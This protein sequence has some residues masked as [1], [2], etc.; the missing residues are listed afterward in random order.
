MIDG[1]VAADDKVVNSAV[2]GECPF[3][4]VSCACSSGGVG[5]YI[6]GRVLGKPCET[7]GEGARAGSIGGV[8]ASDGGVVRC[9]PADTS[10]GDG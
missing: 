10:G 2:G 4:A 7:A 3:W 9:A 5:S 8:A 1:R 6:I